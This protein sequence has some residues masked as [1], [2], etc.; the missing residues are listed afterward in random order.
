MTLAISC[1]VKNKC[2]G[3]GVRLERLFTLMYN[4][5]AWDI[6]SETQEAEEERGFQA[7]GRVL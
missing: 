5:T 7:E 2:L 1:E 6:I 4:K 3:R